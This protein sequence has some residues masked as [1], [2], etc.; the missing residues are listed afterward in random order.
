MVYVR[1]L[2]REQS[3]FIFQALKKINP[4]VP[5]PKSIENRA[6]KHTDEKPVIYKPSE[7]IRGI[8]RGDVLQ[9]PFD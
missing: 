4:D 5:S 9:D 3:E 7:D 2:H 1:K 8:I 6:L